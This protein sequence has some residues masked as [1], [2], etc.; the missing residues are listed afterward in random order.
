MECYRFED[1]GREGR[2]STGVSR[3][4]GLEPNP[5]GHLESR[6]QIRSK[7][8]FFFFERYN[9]EL[10]HNFLKNTTKIYLALLLF[11]IIFF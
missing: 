2:S 3:P 10:F 11:K 6:S 9:L 1:G 7:I 8:S 5:H 4:F